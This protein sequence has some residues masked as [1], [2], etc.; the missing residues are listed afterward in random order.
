MAVKVKRERPD[1]RRHHRVTAPLLVNVGGWRMRAADWSLGGLR[2]EGY[3]E[4][5]PEVGD[6]LALHLTLPFQGFDVAFQAKAQVVRNDPVAAM[7]AVRFTEI[8][9]RERELMQH[10]IEELVR[11]SMVEI[12]DTINRIDVPVTPASLKPDPNPASEVPLRR[13]PSKT[14]V[15]SALYG[16]LG[17]IVFGYTALLGYTN[18]YRLEVQTAV[19]AAPVAQIEAQVDGRLKSVAVVPGDHVEKGQVLID[20]V[21]N[22]LEREIE[23]AA[24]AVKEQ[25]A[26]LAY[27]RQRQL[28]ELDKVESYATLEMKNVQQSRLDLD[29]LKAQL[30]AARRDL[31]RIETIHRQGFATDARLDQSVKEAARLEK[32]VERAQIELT[33]R[34]RLAQSNLGKRLFTGER[35]E[36]TLADVEAQVHLAEHTIRISEQK[37]ETL[38]RQRERLAVRAPFTGTVLKVPRGADSYVRR[39]DV[40]AVV[41]QRQLRR[42]DAYLTQDEVLRVGLGD[43]V[44]LFVPALARTLEGRIAEI[45]RTSGFVREQDQRANPGYAWR[46]PTDRSARVAIAFTDP[47]SVADADVYRAGLP[48]VAVFEQRSTNSLLAALRKKLAVI[49]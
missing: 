9:E 44:T 19:I 43:R 39:G 49:E 31:K 37:A 34:A 36:G 16:V 47:K 48:V 8:G 5:V 4:K 35:L 25:K 33:S 6:E 28:D 23:L 30:L 20:V 18:F 1:Q 21:D 15:M 26:R 38:V 12:D 24:I 40:I 13:R 17:L 3:P 11:G 42:V 14:L 27:L 29:S 2:I 32:A 10:F 41:E 45:D 46:G 22:Q 7:F